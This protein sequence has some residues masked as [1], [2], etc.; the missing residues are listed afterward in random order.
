MFFPDLFNLYSEMIMR[1][2]DGQKIFVVGGHNINNL[3]YAHDTVLLAESEKDLQR[4][5][6]IVVEQ[7]KKK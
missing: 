2:L 5:L 7:S 4:L 1:E 6:D 3:R